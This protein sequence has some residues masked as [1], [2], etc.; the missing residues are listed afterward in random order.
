MISILSSY[1]KL[2][3]GNPR[4]EGPPPRIADGDHLEMGTYSSEMFKCHLLK[5]IYLCWRSTNGIFSLLRLVDVALSIQP[6]QLLRRVIDPT[7]YYQKS[8]ICIAKSWTIPASCRQWKYARAYTRILRGKTNILERHEIKHAQPTNEKGVCL[9]L[10]VQ[11]M[12]HLVLQSTLNV[13]SFSRIIKEV[14]WLI[15]MPRGL[16]QSYQDLVLFENLFAQ[17]LFVL[18]D[19]NQRRVARSSLRLPWRPLKRHRLRNDG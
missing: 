11:N 15:I 6:L 13:P 3:L 12:C 10:Y 2:W 5:K 17:N 4:V 14:T 16:S 8:I 1:H 19:C 7:L 9:F 18:F